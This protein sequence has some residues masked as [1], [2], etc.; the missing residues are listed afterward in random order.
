MHWHNLVGHK[1]TRAL[2]TYIT[3]EGLF[4]LHTVLC[5]VVLCGA[6]WCCAVL[7]GAILCGVVWCCVVLCCVVLCCVVLCG[8]VLCCAVWCCVVLCCVVLCCVVLYGSVLCGAVLC[9]IMSTVHTNVCTVL[10]EGLCTLC[11]LCGA[12]LWGGVCCGDGQCCGIH[13]HSHKHTVIWDS[14]PVAFYTPLCDHSAVGMEVT[15]V[16]MTSRIHQEFSQIT[17]FI[18]SESGNCTSRGIGTDVTCQ[19]ITSDED[20]RLGRNVW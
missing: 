2:C 5:C 9:G 20:P 12:V 1:R 14:V 8:A 18:A 7:C 17:T 16:N 11:Q 13:R 19:M 3:L 15:M 10:L 4:T 6:V